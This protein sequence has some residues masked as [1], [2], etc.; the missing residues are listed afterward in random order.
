MAIEAAVDGLGV[1]LGR[2]PLIEQD[3]ATNRLV[4]VLGPPRFCS[5]GYWLVMQRESI[6]RPEVNSF[7]NWINGELRSSGANTAI[8]DAP[9]TAC[10]RLNDPDL[11]PFFGGGGAAMRA[12]IVST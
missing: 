6:L 1:V 10:A 5:T 8:N 3:L 11:E 7:R 12:C 4:A 9:H 2:L